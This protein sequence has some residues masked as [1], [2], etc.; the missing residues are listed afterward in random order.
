MSRA[1]MA[2]KPL[3]HTVIALALLLA[4]GVIV[5]VQQHVLAKKTLKL[6]LAQ[7]AGIAN[8]DRSETGY[9]KLTFETLKS[10]TYVAG[11]T[12][13]PPHIKALDGQN[14]EMLG[15]MMPLTEIQNIKEFVLM[16]TLFGCCYGQPP[17][18]N[19]MVMVKLPAGRT[20]KFCSNPVRV[21][22]EFHV[23][24][25]RQDGYL[26]SLYVLSANEVSDTR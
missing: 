20:T 15:F 9:S 19:H 18:P 4:T 3:R 17:A 6:G 10:W 1:A 16:P 7:A 23:G 8:G 21:R 11:K 2:R 14:V 12:P 22:G 26:I 24:E 13:F 5:A 25:T